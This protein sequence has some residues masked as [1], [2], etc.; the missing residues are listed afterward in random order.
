MSRYHL[1]PLHALNSP[2][3]VVG[4]LRSRLLGSIDPSRKQ[5][6]VNKQLAFSKFL[7]I[8][9]FGTFFIILLSKHHLFA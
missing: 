5:V 2:M 1:P 6:A 4:S 9:N 8:I 3:L 7:K